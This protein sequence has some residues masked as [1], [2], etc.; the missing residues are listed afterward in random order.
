MLKKMMLFA[1]MALAAAAVAAPAASA[2]WKDNHKSFTGETTVEMEGHAFFKGFLNSGV[3]C[4]KAFFK[5]TV[6]KQHATVTEFTVTNPTTECEGTGLLSSCIPEAPDK[7]GTW[8]VDALS[9]SLTITGIQFTS[10]FANCEPTKVEN[11]EVTATP[12]KTN[13]T[14]GA[15]EEV[16]LSGS[17]TTALGA[18]SIGGTLSVLGTPTLGIS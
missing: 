18:V 3:T 6:D 12:T 1:C 14:T 17:A 8:T 9:T 11:G 4:K 16:S 15:I 7:E 2:E 5:I 10:T 13:A